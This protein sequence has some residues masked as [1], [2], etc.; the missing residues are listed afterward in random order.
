M[1]VKKEAN[2]RRSVQ[3]EAE[4]PGTPEEVWQAIATGPGISSWFVPTEFEIKDGKP[5]A[6]TLNFGPGMESTSTVT[7]WDPSKKKWTSQSEGWV[8]GMPPIAHEW[9]VEAGTGGICVVRIVQ[10]LFASTDDWDNQ[11]EATEYGWPA[12]LRTLRIYLTHFRGERST[13]MKWMATFAGTEAEA[14]ETL[15][16]PLGLQGTSVGQRWTS[17]AG[18]PELGGVV[19]YFTQNPN[20]ALLR[21][22]K[23]GPGVAALGT[24]NCGGPIMVALNFYLY[25]D[26][27]AGTV[28]RESPHWDAWFQK[29][30]PMPVEAGQND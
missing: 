4:V 22:D 6:V 23:P 18:A 29:R 12:F 28:T 25:G 11:L 15:T 20:D 16:A 13:V 27:A 30:F 17:P 5:V 19:E 21:L 8:P 2:G 14:W 3:V 26:Q 7:S 24:F 1:S 9:S 10:S